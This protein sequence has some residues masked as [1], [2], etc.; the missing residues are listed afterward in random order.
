MTRLLTAVVLSSG[1]CAPPAYDTGE[2]EGETS[3]DTSEDSSAAAETGDTGARETGDTAP[4]ETGDTGEP[5]AGSPSIR[6]VFP[7]GTSDAR[8]CPSVVVVV[9]IGNYDVVDY[10]DVSEP[11]EGEGHWHLRYLETF[12]SVTEEWVEV[13]IDLKTYPETVLLEAVLAQSDWNHA[14]AEYQAVLAQSDHVELDTA[15]WPD[16]TAAV[17]ILV[18]DWKGCKGGE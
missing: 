18:D 2:E 13:E 7:D 3:D 12:R 9:D 17:E 14:L 11:H 15:T 8:Y 10:H 16:A 6:F 4:E 1:A 5:A